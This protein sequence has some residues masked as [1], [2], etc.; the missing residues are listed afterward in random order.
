[1]AVLGCAGAPSALG[2]SLS[3]GGMLRI[4]LNS[5]IRGTDPGVNRDA[6]T[7][8]V[9]HHIVEALVAHDELLDVSPSVAER[10]ELLDD[11][12]TY[13]FHLR[14]GLRFH[15]GAPVTSRE[16]SWSLRRVLEPDSGWQCRRWYVAGHPDDDDDGAPSVIESVEAPDDHTV[17][18]RLAEPSTLFLPRLAN[19]QCIP[20]ILHP[21]SL[22]ADGRWKAPI[23]TGPYRLAA[24]RRGEYVELERFE[25]YV[26]RGGAPDGLVG[27]K[28]ALAERL[29]FV[30]SPDTAATKAA[31][32]SGQVDVVPGL[33]M[34]AAEDLRSATG[35][36]VAI[37][38]TLD[39]TAL[40]VQTRDPVL[41]DPRVRRAIA[42]AIDRQ[43]LVNFNAW[44]QA[45]VNSSAVPAGIA[46]HSAV[47]DLWYDYDIERARA[48][49]NEAGY[50][51][52]P[53][54]IQT[55]RRYEYMYSNAVVIQ[56]MLH[57]AGMN[58]HIQVIDWASQLGNYYSGRYQLSTFGFSAIAVPALR[59]HKLIGSKDDRPVFMWESDSAARLLGEAIQT[60]DPARHQALLDQLHREMVRD[61]P[62]IGLYNPHGAT[63][64]RREVQGFQPWAMNLPR[65]WGVSRDG[66][67]P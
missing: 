21:D 46:A 37:A 40:L 14:Q 38:T 45:S 10:W 48:L 8:T 24:W 17:V 61:V 44:G 50:R 36:H 53:I 4:A 33:P 9:M 3:G 64:L 32:L 62:I 22:D 39:W 51:G 66:W 28:H 47:H 30:I 5:D 6:N 16:V 27:A 1:M 65:L 58:A 19:I 20:A 35:V 55:N 54:R 63:A 49:L 41:A 2:A 57:A 42:H 31:L 11:Q 60:T 25:A 29:R 52:Q 67:R 59:Y 34:S 26:P 13:V 12:R 56:A 18:I 23:G 7:D 43:M 15:N